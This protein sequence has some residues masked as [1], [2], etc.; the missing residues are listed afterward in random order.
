MHRARPFTQNDT[1]CAPPPPTTT[2]DAIGVPAGIAA[3]RQRG[4]EIGVQLT[5]WLFRKVNFMIS[6]TAALTMANIYMS[7]GTFGYEW[8]EQL[9]TLEQEI[10]DLWLED[11]ARLAAG[12][13][14]YTELQVIHSFRAAGAIAGFAAGQSIGPAIGASSGAIYGV[15]GVGLSTAIQ[16]AARAYANASASSTPAGR[17]LQSL[18]GTE[19][20]ADVFVALVRTLLAEGEKKAPAGGDKEGP[21]RK[22]QTLASAMGMSPAAK[23]AV[24]ALE[25]D[26]T[27]LSPLLSEPIFR[28]AATSISIGA[29]TAIGAGAASV[30]GWRIGTRAGYV[31]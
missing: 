10:V 17:R 15:M 9:N 26:L 13:F 5:R 12:N 30:G 16:D 20:A 28:W 1:I 27:N 2:P 29:A 31:V 3:G 23:A 18:L 21:H 24:G 11:D 19:A 4:T 7:F 6:W 14:T 8:E 25:G 22:A